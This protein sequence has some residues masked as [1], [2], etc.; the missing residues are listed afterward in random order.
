MDEIE[1]GILSSIPPSA[2]NLTLTRATIRMEHSQTWR[3][4]KTNP[5]EDLVICLEGR[6]HYL[7][8]GEPRVME[9]GDAMLITR[10]QR[11]QGWNE[12]AETYIGIAQHFTLDIYGRYDLLAQMELQPKIRLSRWSLLEPLARHYRQGAPPSSITLGQHHLFMYFLI[13]FIEDAFIGWRGSA[14]YQPEGGDALDLAVMKAA[15][16]IAANPLD[17]DIAIRAVE[18]SPYNHDY[19]LRAFQKRVGRTP[20][21]YQEFKRMERAMHFLEG[22]MPVAAAAAEV[23][24]TDPYYFSRMFKRNLGLSP[25]AHVNKVRQSRHGGLLGFDEPDQELRLTGMEDEQGR[26]AA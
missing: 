15:T 19:F 16:M 26:D 2:L 24:Y 8:D 14:A 18:A 13:A 11:F 1:G 22:G 3:I 9:P 17:V 12:G 7:I 6:G 5:V 10:G 20:R 25:R 21:K 4:D 23:G